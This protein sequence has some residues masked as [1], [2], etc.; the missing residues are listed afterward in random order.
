MTNLT[1]TILQIIKYFKFIKG[2]KKSNKVVLQ[3]SISRPSVGSKTSF[4][5]TK[6]LCKNQEYIN[7]DFTT[8]YTDHY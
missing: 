4:T 7:K 2:N 8:Y 3:T 5:I 6:G 1:K